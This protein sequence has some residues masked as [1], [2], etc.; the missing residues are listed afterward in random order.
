M[1]AAT[2]LVFPPRALRG[3]VCAFITRDTGD[4]APAQTNRFPAALFCTITWFI[5]GKTFDGGE[6]SRTAL[7]DVIVT[8]PFKTTA[9]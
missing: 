3:C 8:G 7:D 5:T 1:P 6:E 2:R 4:G 9:N